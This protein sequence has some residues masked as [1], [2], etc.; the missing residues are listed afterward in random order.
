MG[1]EFGGARLNNFNFSQKVSEDISDWM[2]G[3]CDMLIFSGGVGIGKTHFASAMYAWFY[4]KVPSI[5]MYK[6]TRFFRDLYCGMDSKI[7]SSSLIDKIDDDLLIWDD[8]G[9]EKTENEWVKSIIHEIFDYRHSYRKPTIITTNLSSSQILHV[10]GAR[11]WDRL[12]DKRNKVIELFDQPSIRANR[13]L[14]E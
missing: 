14:I 7:N 1:E 13:H 2:K 11:I 10:Y 5:R 8:L 4:G 12:M 9:V 6:E 3:K